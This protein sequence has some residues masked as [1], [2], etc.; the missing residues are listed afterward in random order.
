MKS[1]KVRTP[2]PAAVAQNVADGR[3]WNWAG[4]KGWAD[5]VEPRGLGAVS[6]GWA[7]G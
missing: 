4:K 7:L 3:A 5:K 2:K 6:L 1:S